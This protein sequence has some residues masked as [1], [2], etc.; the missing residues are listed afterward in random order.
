MFVMHVSPCETRVFRC[1]H[2]VFTRLLVAHFQTIALLVSGG[3][4]LTLD[5]CDCRQDGK[6]TSL[7]SIST[8]SVATAICNNSSV[9]SGVR[10]ERYNTVW[11]GSCGALQMVMQIRLADEMTRGNRRGIFRGYQIRFETLVCGVHHH[12]DGC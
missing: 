1:A 4:R 9:R 12:H 3:Y 11:A 7:C 5:C 2:Q 10:G 8:A 6:L